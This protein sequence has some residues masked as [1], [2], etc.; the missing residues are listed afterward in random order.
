MN[1]LEEIEMAHLRAECARRWKRIV[2]LAAKNVSL[3][4]E[5]AAKEKVV[6]EQRAF[7]AALEKQID[8]APRG[9]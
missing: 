3:E 7:I 8:G 4:S 5:L 9:E 2:E 1:R 6:H